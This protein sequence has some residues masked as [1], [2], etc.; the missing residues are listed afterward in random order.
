MHAIQDGFDT[1]LNDL[2]Q[3]LEDQGRQVDL[4]VGLDMVYEPV[5]NLAHRGVLRPY[6]PKK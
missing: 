1:A 3:V 5:V 4:V 2:D 6:E